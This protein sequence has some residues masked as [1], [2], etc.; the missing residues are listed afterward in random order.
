MGVLGEKESM[1]MHILSVNMYSWMTLN[2]WHGTTYSKSA[3]SKS[4]SWWLQ[5][6]WQKIVTFFKPAEF[7]FVAR[8]QEVRREWFRCFG[9]ENNDSESAHS[10]GKDNWTAR[11]LAGKN[12]YGS[13]QS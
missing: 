2:H 5:G 11:N 7:V 1:M 12:K 8:N 4:F 10:P 3:R 6:H 9:I 13:I